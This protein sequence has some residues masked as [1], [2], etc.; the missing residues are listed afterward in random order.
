MQERTECPENHKPYRN[1]GRGPATAPPGDGKRTRPAQTGNAR[2]PEPTTAAGAASP[3]GGAGGGHDTSTPR[4]TAPSS[5]AALDPGPLG[6]ARPVAAAR[7]RETLPRRPLAP[8]AGVRDDARRA[9]PRQPCRRWGGPSHRAAVGRGGGAVPCARSSPSPSPPSR[10]LPRGR[11]GLRLPEGSR[12]AAAAAW[13]SAGCPGGSAGSRGQAWACSSPSCGVSSV[14]K[15]GAGGPSRPRG[16]AV[17]RRGGGEE[18]ASGARGA[19]GGGGGGGGQPS[20]AGGLLW[21]PGFP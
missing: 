4:G 16:G 5:P 14:A 12:G 11:R 19:E 8:A 20:E 3:P 17:G 1:E 21:S 10:P 13:L 6:R 15:V 18:G 9:A 2:A 7:L